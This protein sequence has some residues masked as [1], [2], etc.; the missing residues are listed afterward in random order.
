M[1]K[2]ASRLERLIA[3]SR[4]ALAWESLW[5]AVSWALAAL[6]LFEGLP[7][8]WAKLVDGVLKNHLPKGLR[9]SLTN[10]APSA[11]IPA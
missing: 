1:R 10:S 2:G 8:G 11:I 9:R 6:A 4:A 7:L 3:L 5:R